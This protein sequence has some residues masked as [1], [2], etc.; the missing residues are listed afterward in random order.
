MPLLTALP[1]APS[2]R[3]LR[4]FAGVHGSILRAGALWLIGVCGAELQPAPWGEAF[5]LTVQHVAHA[6]VVVSCGCCC[7]HRQHVLSQ[8]RMSPM[9][10]VFLHTGSLNLYKPGLPSFPVSTHPSTCRLWQCRP[11][12]C[13]SATCWRRASVSG[14]CVSTQ[15]ASFPNTHQVALMAVS[16]LTVLLS[17]TLEESQFVSAP[18][19]R[20]RLILEGPLAALQAGTDS[21]DEAAGGMG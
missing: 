20:K 7:F 8:G 14:G 16:A 19:Q 5:T 18:A 3:L 1:T 9:G 10:L 11:S 13:C 12:P 4:P 6:D 2:H 17:N 21:E 15:V